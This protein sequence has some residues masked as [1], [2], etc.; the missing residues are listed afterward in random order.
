M[1]PQHF[2][3]LTNSR[4]DVRVKTE[5][6]VDLHTELDKMIRTPHTDCYPMPATFA[7]QGAGEG[8]FM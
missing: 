4:F 5:L 6:H 3:V 1:Q 2:W 8:T 7:W